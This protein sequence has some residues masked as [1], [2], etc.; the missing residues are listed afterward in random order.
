MRLETMSND[1][2]LNI[3]AINL[4]D[5]IKKKIKDNWFDEDDGIHSTERLG[6]MVGYVK[7]L[8]IG[9][10]SVC[11]IE[12]CSESPEE[13]YNVWVTLGVIRE[14]II[15]GGYGPW[16]EDPEERVAELKGMYLSAIDAAIRRLSGMQ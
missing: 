15:R 12:V 2:I 7:A 5:D 6:I 9:M 14:R 1:E 10:N 8:E 16:F 3:A 4:L 13:E 11:K